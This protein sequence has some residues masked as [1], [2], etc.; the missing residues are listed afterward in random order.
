MAVSAVASSSSFS[1]TSEPMLSQG[2]RGAAVVTL[3]NALRAAGFSP[4]ASDGVFGPGTRAA[5][6]AFQRARGLSQDGVAGPQ[7]WSALAR[8]APAASTGGSQPT[9][10]YGSTG[11]AVSTMQQDL[12]RAGFNPGGVDGNFGPNT[13]AALKRFQSA[14]GLT[15][16]G[17]CGPQTWAAL[18]GSSFTSAPTQSTGGGTGTTL[19]EGSTGPAVTRLQSLLQDAGCSP[20]GI[21]GN[22][23]PMTQ[24]AVMQYQAS[25]GLSVDGVVGPQTWAALNSNKPAVKSVGGGTGTGSGGSSVVAF[26]QT[27]LGTPIQSLKDSGPLAPYLDQWPPDDVCC[28]NFVSAVLEKEG[29]ITPGEHD[30]NVQGL[31]D[32]LAADPHWS[33]TS[34]ANAKPGDV[35]CFN[36]PGE[37]PMSHVEIFEGWQNGEP[38]FIGSNNVLSDGDQAISQGV[39]DY[40]VGAVYHYNG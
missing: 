15:Q 12:A 18:D 39:V 5:V 36:V 32:N 34:L 20:G 16:D 33:A 38:T 27:L 7:T 23:G 13:Q 35:V 37:G 6:L 19:Q 14:H 4:G 22:F 25:R 17:I 10:S 30:D 9:L 21:D 3:Q 29:Q 31:A 2:S 28:A 26:A 11:S 8:N 40:P 1:P 24:A